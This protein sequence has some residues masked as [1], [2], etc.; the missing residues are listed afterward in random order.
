VLHLRVFKQLDKCVMSSKT[1]KIS[2]KNPFWEGVQKFFNSLMAE[3]TYQDRVRDS[4]PSTPLQICFRL[5]IS[6][7]LF[8]T[9][10]VVLPVEMP[11]YLVI[12]IRDTSII[13]VQC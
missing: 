4:D 5:A 3:P 12:V 8:R 1:I 9:L 13:E 2:I 7:H 11:V 6:L 10:G